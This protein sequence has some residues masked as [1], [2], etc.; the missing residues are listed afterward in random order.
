MP[1]RLVRLPDV[2]L[3]DL[4]LTRWPLQ[5]LEPD[6]DTLKQVVRASQQGYS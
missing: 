6:E 3:P 5:V 1:A 2:C 4:Y